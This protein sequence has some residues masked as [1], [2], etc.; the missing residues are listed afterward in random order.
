[1]SNENILIEINEDNSDN[2]DNKNN[3]DDENELE[4]ILK[5]INEASLDINTN[6]Y[7]YNSESEFMI[8]LIDYNLNYN[9]KQLLL[10]CEYYGLLKEIKTNKMKKLEIIYF[11]LDFEENIEN[12]SIV[13][14][15]KQ[16]WHFINELKNDKFMKKY[17][18]W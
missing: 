12:F 7:N 5:E 10:I 14:K 4:N 3:N 6:F 15:R 9:N 18:L 16:L 13:N 1:M 17:V 11:L 2:R 8:K